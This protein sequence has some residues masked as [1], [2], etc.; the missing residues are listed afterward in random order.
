MHRSIHKSIDSS[1]SV[2]LYRSQYKIL[3]VCIS[4]HTHVC[5]RARFF[6][7]MGSIP[8]MAPSWST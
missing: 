1:L 6:L 8:R 7:C 4:I 2:H 3:S 5:E